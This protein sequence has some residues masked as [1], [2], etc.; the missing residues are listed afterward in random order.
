[1]AAL[2][3]S[4]VPEDYNPYPLP[5]HNHSANDNSLLSPVTCGDVLSDLPEPEFSIDLSHRSYSKAKYMGAHCQGQNEINLFGLGPTIRSEH[6]GNIEYRRLSEEHGG[7]YLNELKDGK[8]ERRLSPRECALIQTFPPDY[9][10]VFYQPYTK[11]MAVSGSG[12]YKVI[13]NAVPPM[14]AYNIAIRLEQQW[15]KYFK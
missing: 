12:A 9:P 3:S 10:F 11:K 13:G 2:T 1:M 7:K 14:L 5:T 8:K 6:H 15:N 4:I